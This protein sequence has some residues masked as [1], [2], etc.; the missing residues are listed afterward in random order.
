MKVLETL[1]GDKDKYSMT[2]FK[3]LRGAIYKSYR[4]VNRPYVALYSKLNFFGLAINLYLY[5]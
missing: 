2:G 3:T 5:Y 1:R 4:R